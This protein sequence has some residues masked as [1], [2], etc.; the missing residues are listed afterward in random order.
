LT[1]TETAERTVLGIL[2]ESPG[3]IAEVGLR[4][5]HFRTATGRQVYQAL[6][7]LEREGA[8][9]DP[10]TVAARME[11]SGIGSGI[12]DMVGYLVGL[13]EYSIRSG[14]LG[15][16][17]TMLE[18]RYMA[19]RAATISAGVQEAIERG[20]SGAEARDRAVLDLQQIETIGCETTSLKS[21]AAQEIS[22]IKSDIQRKAAGERLVTGLPLPMGLDRVVPTG[23]PFSAVTV[24]AG[25]TKSGKSTVAQNIIWD[26]ALNGH[27]VVFF[28]VEDGLEVFR[29]KWLSAR[30]GIPLEYILTRRLNPADITSLE[31]L[32]RDTE[33]ACER[34]IIDGTAGPSPE[35]VVRLA[36]RH[37]KACNAK[38]VVVDYL[39]ILAR[40]GI[41]REGLRQAML[42]FQHAAKADGIAYL[43]VSQLNRGHLKDRE[44]PRPRRQDLYGSGSIEQFSKLILGVYRPARFG[45]PV[46]GRHYE[47]LHDI[48]SPAVW[49]SRLELWVL[50]NNKGEDNIYTCAS[51][52]RPTGRIESE[53][54]DKVEDRRRPAALKSPPAI[55]HDLLEEKLRREQK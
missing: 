51:W 20:A 6:L 23:L 10:V 52:N 50:G 5:E 7:A 17:A 45:P 19:L 47:G 31:L 54:G 9:I 32:A 43:V 40:Q 18:D 41:E 16:Y 29:Q 13:E 4:P 22:E 1:P 30:S 24:L 33:R 2:L 25:D 36:R 12:P 28:S 37:A 3:R 27:G 46:E 21:E 55:A 44:D 8:L 39:Q 26:C 14:T 38:L 15:K 49:N 48:P 11:Q 42:T 35:D 34:V 53:S